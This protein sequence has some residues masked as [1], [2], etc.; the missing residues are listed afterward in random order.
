MLN[1][2]RRFSNDRRRMFYWAGTFMCVLGLLLL[3]LLMVR[4]FST[5]KKF[6]PTFVAGYCAIFASLLSVFQILEHLTCFVDPECQTKV[7]RI[8]FMVPLFALIS[9]I[10][11]CAPSAAGYL[12]LIRD[13]Y[14][15]YVIYAF[16]QLMIALMGGLD[17][18]YRNLMIEERPLLPHVFPLCYLEPI[19]VSP[20]FVQ[21]CRL[22]LFQFMVVKPLVTIGIVV[23]EAKGWMGDSLLDPTKGYFWTTLVYNVSIT[24]AFTALL[25][26]YSGLKD[27]MEGK[28]ALMK[29]LCVK[30]VIF[31]S[32][33]QGLLIQILA[34]TGLL[35]SVSYWSPEE[36]PTAL[37]DLLICM[38][39][40][41]VAFAHKYC[42]SSDEFHAGSDI[43]IE[44]ADMGPCIDD[45]AS[46]DGLG[47]VRVPPMRLSVTENLKFTLRHEDI[48]KD[49][50]DIVRNVGCPHAL[51][52]CPMALLSG[53]ILIH[54]L[55][56]LAGV[57]IYRCNESN[58]TVERPPKV[59]VTVV[60]HGQNPI[61]CSRVMG[62]QKPV[63]LDE[64]IER[65][66]EMIRALEYQCQAVSRM[67]AINSDQQVRIRAQRD[68]ALR[69]AAHTTLKTEE[70][71]QTL[72][73]QVK[74]MTNLS[75]TTE[76]HLKNRHSNLLKN[77]AD[78]ERDNEE[79]R[80]KLAALTE[81]KEADLQ[82]WEKDVA[83]KEA[84]IEDK[85]LNFGLR[86]KET[87]LHLDIR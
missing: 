34:A 67:L 46:S 5:D 70:V 27:L 54:P 33:W 83:E 10:S 40:M 36:T 38:E 63:N 17:T 19:R 26:F 16:F 43:R 30:S 25:Y 3:T 20:L 14:E 4:T 47:V 21:K 45:A 9:W 81:R 18:V 48:L 66:K 44:S 77:L 79:L 74:Y 86:L 32:F 12:N 7:V 11:L 73:T 39:M 42:F 1:H 62:F 71:D 82:R 57:L 61:L 53:V 6:V 69:S 85:A 31:L 52:G 84:Q 65:K 64:Q 56:F 68:D 13:T 51:P 87:L 76:E 49:V 28:N 50:S 2:I 80:K 29:F 15:A 59:A 75:K 55:F 22:C 23:L 78:V 60:V 24:V 58:K 35:P 37:Q 41:L 72:E 8:L